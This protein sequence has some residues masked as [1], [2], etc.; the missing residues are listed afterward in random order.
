MTNQHKM[1][2]KAEQRE[3]ESKER[4]VTEWHTL[5]FSTKLFIPGYSGTT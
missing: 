3:N 2:C 5:I 1:E 4:N